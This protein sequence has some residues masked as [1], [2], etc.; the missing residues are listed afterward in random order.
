MNVCECGKLFPD[1]CAAQCVEAER[2]DLR[3]ALKNLMDSIGGGI[4][5][6]GHDFNC[7]CAW[8]EAKKVLGKLRH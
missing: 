7:V 1:E 8:D 5:Y 3:D 2:N 6:C 4:K